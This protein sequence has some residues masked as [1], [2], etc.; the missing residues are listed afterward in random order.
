LKSDIGA[1]ATLEEF[2][3]QCDEAEP[4]NCAFAPDSEARFYELADRLREGPL[5]FTDP[6]SG[7]TF[8]YLY[9]F[10]VSD[11]LGALYGPDNFPL[12]AFYLS[13]LEASPDAETLG[14]ARAELYDAPSYVN[15]R[16]F[17]NYPNFVEGF[18][19][20]AC[21]DSVSP[22][23]AHE[24][25]FEVGKQATEDNGIFGELWTWGSQPCTLWSSADEDVYR[26]PYTAETANPVLV[27]GNFYDPATRYE[28][29]QTARGLLPN[30]A[31][32]SVDEPGHTSLGISGCA[33]FFTGLYLADPSVGDP[34]AVNTIDGVTCGSEGNWFDKLA[35]PPG[36]AGAGAAFRANIMDEVAY[37]P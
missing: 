18:P 14:F 21:E 22:D 5:E 36:G 15:K 26:G 11:V 37:R 32:L 8:P 27:I 1:L 13:A 12:L 9:Q 31:L 3:R 30:S 4:G 20:V 19:G 17:P 34:T 6:F 28:G 7:E 25:W 33:G 2:F 16:G 29:A 35:G 10:L 24:L 23:G